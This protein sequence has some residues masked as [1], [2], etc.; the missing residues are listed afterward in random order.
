MTNAR[1]TPQLYLWH[2][3]LSWPGL[4]LSWVF[5]AQGLQLSGL[6]L[7]SDI[8]GTQGKGAHPGF[9][10]GAATSECGSAPHPWCFGAWIF[11][12]TGFFD[13]HWKH[14]PTGQIPLPQQR[15]DGHGG[16]R[17]SS[18]AGSCTPQQSPP[19]SCPAAISTTL[20][21]VLDAPTCR[22]EEEFCS[23]VSGVNLVDFGDFLMQ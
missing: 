13:G 20:L 11:D 6:S 4:S 15:S 21:M 12:G 14:F 7:L 1:D 9:S 8:L 3:S 18:G 23:S 16:R 10:S 19:C 2:P 5:K 17:G 22:N